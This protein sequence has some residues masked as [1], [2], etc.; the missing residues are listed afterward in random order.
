MKG[1]E[2]KKIERMKVRRKEKKE[3]GKKEIMKGRNEESIMEVNGR[4]ER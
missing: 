2:R 1:K 4:R 3:E